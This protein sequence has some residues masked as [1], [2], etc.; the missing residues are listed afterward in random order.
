M[1]S[2]TKVFLAA[3]HNLAAGNI[4]GLG[5]SLPFHLRVFRLWKR[6]CDFEIDPATSDAISKGRGPVLPDTMTWTC[7][8][9]ALL[10]N[11]TK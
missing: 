2:R 5:Y 8:Q 3:K 9:Q 4:R 11:E 7:A 10:A 6:P 1:A